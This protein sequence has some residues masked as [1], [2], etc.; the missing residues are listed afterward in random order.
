MGPKTLLYTSLKVYL[1]YRTSINF[2]LA[3]ILQIYLILSLSSPDSI[4][5]VFRFLILDMVKRVFLDGIFPFGIEDSFL[6]SSISLILYL[7]WYSDFYYPSGVLGSACSPSL[8]GSS[9][10]IIPVLLV[11]L[12]V[13]LLGFIESALFLLAG[14]DWVKA[15]I[16][17]GAYSSGLSR[18][19]G[20]GSLL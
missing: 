4:S 11:L 2:H 15:E 6:L 9:Y 3:G 13:F 10:P 8:P 7:D 18:K 16:I 20:K 5:L 12:A 17:T 14:S 1:F 19:A